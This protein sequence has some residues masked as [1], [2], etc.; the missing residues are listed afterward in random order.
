MKKG[1]LLI[2]LFFAVMVFVGATYYDYSV[3]HNG[4]NV[5]I[6][7]RTQQ[8]EGLKQFVIERKTPQT[9]FEGIATI[10]PKGDNSS[11]S[12]T[13]E[14]AYK[15]TDLVFIYRIKFVDYD[16]NK[17]AYSAEKSVLQ[18]GLSDVKR[19]WGSIKAMFR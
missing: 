13:D 7:W 14:S 5:I 12:Y 3:Y 11:Y 18:N 19:T 9:S 4:D 2:L 15:T 10:K 1:I 6:S 17:T 8:E 16:P